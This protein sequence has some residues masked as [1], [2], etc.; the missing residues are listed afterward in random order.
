MT[1]M[2]LGS[3]ALCFSLVTAVSCGQEQTQTAQQMDYSSQT[4]AA[5]DLDQGILTH[6]TDC[7]ISRAFETPDDISSAKLQCKASTLKACEGLLE[8][9]GR[10]A[11]RAKCPSIVEKAIKWVFEE[12]NGIDCDSGYCVV[13]RR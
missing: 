11:H 3:L 2:K 12:A 8:Q 4:G 1:F 7:I 6:Y 13:V 9:Q 5:G 10:S